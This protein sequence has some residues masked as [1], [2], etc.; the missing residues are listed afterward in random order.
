[1]GKGPYKNELIPTYNYY[2]YVRMTNELHTFS[3]QFIPI[4][5]TH[6]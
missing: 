3:Y 5:L 6:D 4:K 2:L 1:V